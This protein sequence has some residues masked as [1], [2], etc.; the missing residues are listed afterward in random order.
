MKLRIWH[1]L[2]LWGVAL[3]VGT[4]GAADMGAIGAARIVMQIIMG[5]GLEILAYIAFIVSCDKWCKR[6]WARYGGKNEYGQ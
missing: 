4:I 2:A 6:Q 5:F 3:L 1:I